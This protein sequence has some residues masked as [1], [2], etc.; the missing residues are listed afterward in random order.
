MQNSWYKCHVGLKHDINV[1]STQVS[2]PEFFPDLTQTRWFE[3]SADLNEFD[4]VTLCYLDNH[5]RAAC[6]KVT[7]AVRLSASAVS[8]RIRVLENTGATQGYRA[9]SDDWLP[10]RGT[11]VFVRVALD[12]ESAAVVGAFEAAVHRCREI[13]SCYLMAGEPDY[14]LV[15]R[16]ASIDDYW[17]F[18]QS[19]LSRLPGVSRL[20]TSFVPRNVLET[21]SSEVHGTAALIMG[22]EFVGRLRKYSDFARDTRMDRA[23]RCLADVQI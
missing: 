11:T 5:D 4:T 2:S 18:H 3:E 20:E 8:R 15:A 6:F 12:N 7:E 1:V 21:R 16:V 10:G 9:L 17:R 19:Q 23:L 22:P 14:M 13:V